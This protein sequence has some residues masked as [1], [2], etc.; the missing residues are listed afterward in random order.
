[1]ERRSQTL[2]AE[3]RAGLR[4]IVRR[5]LH[6]LPPW[7]ELEILE[8][9]SLENCR[10]ILNMQDWTG[11]MQEEHISDFATLMLMLQYIGSASEVVLSPIHQ[12]GPTPV[13]RSSTPHVDRRLRNTNMPRR[14]QN[15]TLNR[16]DPVPHVRW[17]RESLNM[18]WP[19][20]DLALI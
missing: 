9:Q 13:R 18:P 16:M 5:M 19:H 14:Q 20:P 15:T 2:E 12:P 8:Y 4:E 7:N 11:I 6:G 1:M 17:P 10:G 3:L